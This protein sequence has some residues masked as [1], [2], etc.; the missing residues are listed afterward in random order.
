MS[1]WATVGETPPRASSVAGRW[2]EVKG[3]LDRWYQGDRDPEWP[4]ADY[5]RVTAADG[6][7][8]LLRHDREHGEWFLTKP[9]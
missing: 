8:Y 4:I 7:D 9:R 3:I 2:L 1:F 6:R 5:F